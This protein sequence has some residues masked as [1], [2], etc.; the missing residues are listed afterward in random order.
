MQV[1]DQV[2]D[3]DITYLNNESAS[4]SPNSS[5]ESS[6]VSASSVLDNQFDFEPAIR[7]KILITEEKMAQALKD[8]HIKA[9]NNS[10][11]QQTREQ[12]PSNNNNENRRND[13][14]FL[15]DELK[16]TIKYLNNDTSS[17]S[18]LKKLI[19][20]ENQSKMLQLI[21]YIPLEIENLFDASPSSSFSSSSSSY[22]Q[23]PVETTEKTIAYKVEEPI[24]CK[25][26]N[27]LKR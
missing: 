8:L 19:T 23:H 5:S 9:Y 2:F 6:S 21:P 27:L 14:F 22:E 7:R 4:C 24:D 15:S 16:Q 13:R 17:S 10:Q 25:K 26:K 11:H 1:K 3:D 12:S 20:S 18:Q